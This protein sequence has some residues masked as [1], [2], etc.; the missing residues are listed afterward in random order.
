MFSRWKSF[1]RLKGKLIDARLEEEEAEDAS[2]ESS[3]M[4]TMTK[5]STSSIEKKVF[6]AHTSWLQARQKALKELKLGAAFV[7]FKR[8]AP[9]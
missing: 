8:H 7:L 1:E 5:A 6:I 4:P 9:P 2:P 3:R